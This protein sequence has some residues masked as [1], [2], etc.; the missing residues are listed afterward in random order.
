MTNHRRQ[1]KTTTARKE[2]EE[3]TSQRRD[4]DVVVA[5][6]VSETFLVQI[7]GQAIHMQNR[8]MCKTIVADT[9]DKKNQKR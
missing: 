1:E 5:V 2:R 7:H 8:P 4:V 3:N 6:V 9:N